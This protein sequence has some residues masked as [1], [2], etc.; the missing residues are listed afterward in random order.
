MYRKLSLCLL[1]V[2]AV[3]GILFTLVIAETTTGHEDI[4]ALATKSSIGQ[5]E[6]VALDLSSTNTIEA[7]ASE[8]IVTSTAMQIVGQP[9]PGATL[10]PLTIGTAAAEYRAIAPTE[11]HAGM[12]SP[13]MGI[14]AVIEA[15][16]SKPFIET[17][18]Q[19]GIVACLCMEGSLQMISQSTT[20]FLPTSLA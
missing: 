5:H 13:V 7:I 16:G 3:I 18:P 1:L 9:E 10:Y 11:F 15:I 20:L 6:L 12:L 14:P 19:P 2:V 17:G 4:A 8:D